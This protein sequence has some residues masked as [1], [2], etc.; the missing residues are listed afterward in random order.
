MA[1]LRRMTS[2]TPWRG[3]S[4]GLAHAQVVG[5]EDALDRAATVTATSRV[6]S[7]RRYSIALAQG[8]MAQPE[9]PA[10][11]DIGLDR[12]VVGLAR[13]L[14][15]LDED[16]LVQGDADG[17]P[18]LRLESAAPAGSS[19]RSS[20]SRARLVAGREEQPV[21]DREMAA[22][23]A[24]DDDAP[25]VELVD[26]LDRQAQRQLDGPA[27]RAGSS[28]SASI[29]VGPS[30]QGI[31]A[32]RLTRLSPSRAEIGTTKSARAP[33]PV[34]ILGIGAADLLEV[35]RPNSRRDPSC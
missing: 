34:E 7:F 14:A 19:L 18:R 32:A 12:Q 24:P 31:E 25:L 30:Y 6:A 27:R 21:A 8:L 23:D 26:V 22:L 11:E 2:A 29:R 35:A 3:T 5:V 16:L 4:F 28:S 13:D 15:A 17:F 20:G 10:A 1:R 9:Q 33:K